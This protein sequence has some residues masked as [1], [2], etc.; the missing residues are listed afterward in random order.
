MIAS[1]KV[2]DWANSRKGLGVFYV[3]IQNTCAIY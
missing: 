3:V 2:A 1:G